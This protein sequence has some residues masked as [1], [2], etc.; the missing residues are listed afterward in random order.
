MVRHGAEA[1]DQG[2]ASKAQ[3]APVMPDY[4]PLTQAK[5]RTDVNNARRLADKYAEDV[6]WVGPW[7]KFLLWDG[8]RWRLDQSRA[9]DLKAKDIAD[10]IFNELT[11][12]IREE[13]KT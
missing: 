1:Y 13:N 11:T 2:L 6:Q 3:A 9:V 5:G 4:Q 12:F 8:T 10:D 7:D